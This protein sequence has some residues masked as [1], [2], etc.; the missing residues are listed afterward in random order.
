MSTLPLQLRHAR[1]WPK[2]FRVAAGLL[3]FAAASSATTFT[4]STDPFAGISN[5]PPVIQGEPSINFNPATDSFAFD[6]SVF[7]FA[8]NIQFANN[9]IENLPAANVNA[10]VLQTLDNDNNP[11]TPFGAR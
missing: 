3:L 11:A 1:L 2:S 10:I 6:P 5:P 7:S 9:T 4:F 8:G